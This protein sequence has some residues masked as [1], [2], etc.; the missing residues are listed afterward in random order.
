MYIPK[1]NLFTLH[2]ATCMYVFKVYHWIGTTNWC[3]F[4]WERPPLP[5]PASSV[6]YNSLCRVGDA[7]AFLHPIWHIHRCCPCS[8][9]IWGVIL[10]R[11]YWCNFWHYYCWRHHS[12][13]SE[14]GPKASELELT[15]KNSWHQKLTHNLP[16]GEGNRY[17]DPTTLWHLWT[18]SMASMDKNTEG[19]VVAYAPR[20]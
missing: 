9:R 18:K 19:A 10:V 4:F 6:A 7:W 16:K 15:W 20:Q 1:Y 13:T 3:I 17:P 8:V 2:T 12:R 11:L 14:I 5:F